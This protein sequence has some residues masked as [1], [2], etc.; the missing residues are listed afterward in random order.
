MPYAINGEVRI[1]YE[2]EGS[3]PPLVLHPGFVGSA[4]DWGDGGYVAALRDRYKL[5]LLDPRGQGSSD[6]PRDPAAYA[7][8]HRVGDVLAVLDAAGVDRAHFW[9]YSMGGWIG[10][11]LGTYAPDR[12][13]SLVLGGAPHPFEGNPRPTEGDEFLD[14]LQQGMA[15]LV[16]GWEETV[17]DFWLSAGERARWLA[18]DAEALA[19]AR[20]Q[21]LTEPDLPVDA[22]AAISVPALLYTGTLDEPELV[23]RAARLMPN[24]AFVGLED[25]DHAQGLIRSDLVL[26]HVLRFLAQAEDA[27]TTRA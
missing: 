27:L 17:P 24:A 25:L 6:K 10:F 2:V 18:S 9:G 14:G 13:R 11:A 7:R 5:V 26:P 19:A 15:A 12:L 16:R 23:E 3:G 1:C 8:R 21:R 22:L 4:G 20:L